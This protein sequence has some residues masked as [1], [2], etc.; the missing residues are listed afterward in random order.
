M[1]QLD[2]IGRF[3]TVRLLGRGG[4]G[5]VYLARDPLIERH[6]AVKVLAASFDAAARERFTREARAAGRL[7]HEHIVTI[8]DVG[9]HAGRPFIAMEYV[10]GQTL[11]A[12]IRAA[13]PPSRRELLGLLDDACAGLAFAH[14]AGVVHLDVKPENLM[15]HDDGRLKILDFGIARVVAADE[16]HTRHVLG[17]LRYMSPEQ[18]NGGEVD[19]RSDVF[20]I[21]CVLYEVVAGQPAFGAT[22][23]E[24]LAR[25]AGG[26]VP[27][28]ADVVPDVHP[29]L[30][31]IAQK[32]M[33]TDPAARY[34]DL[35]TLRAELAAVRATL[36]D[37]AARP[38][39]V[40]LDAA[41]AAARP[42]TDSGAG[43]P[44]A[45]GGAAAV[46]GARGWALRAVGVAALAVAAAVWYRGGGG[47]TALQQAAPTLPSPAADGAGVVAGPP[48]ASTAAA[49]D[50]AA[51]VWRAVARRDYAAA[52]DLLR[53]Q[54][55][56]ASTLVGELAAAAR[57]AAADARRTVE[58]RGR[59][60]R[61]TAG[62]RAGVEA[63]A[64]A[65]RADGDSATI[66]GLAATWEALDA[67]GRVAIRDAAIVSPAPATAAPA[68]GQGRRTATAPLP[69]ADPGATAPPR[70]LAATPPPLPPPR[71]VTADPPRVDEPIAAS[72]AAR[73]R[74]ETAPP[75]PA[76]APVPAE[77]ASRRG[78]SAEESAR[79]ALA[80][81]QAAYAARD[82][83]ALRRV[84]PG[85]PA[86]QSDALARAFAEAVSYGLNVRVVSLAVGEATVTATA[87]VSHALVPK[88]GSPSKT[89]QTARFTLAP[90]GSGWVIQRIE[91]MR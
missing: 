71:P 54:P 83:A 21:G 32:A 17:T 49:A 72:P 9:E 82:I 45:T 61:E 52:L 19:H 63:L 84:Y 56:V 34:P 81:Y 70:D 47:S 13:S 15:R 27:R 53:S 42:A 38:I 37:A 76:P 18:L 6:V 12:L 79:A 44:T 46:T 69:A 78:P 74:T 67:F 73:E 11:G 75:A 57:T 20:G 1:D 7:H 5:E 58:A 50:V 86:A 51:D 23:P 40:S 10:P 31:R 64:R 33:A 55:A 14:R 88:V 48:P 16:T 77:P 36:D 62:Y 85:L 3:E 60:A 26:T 68:T 43:P 39:T 30:D 22:W 89:T 8:F 24:V 90:M 25:V 4:M 35:D 80:A 2:R 59:A 28:L 41:S 87:E 66:D 65:R 29:G 91:P